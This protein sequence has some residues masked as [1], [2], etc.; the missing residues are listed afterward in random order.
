MDERNPVAM[1]GAYLLFYAVFGCLALT[2]VA[3]AVAIRL[4][5]G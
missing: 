5:G 1:T 3:G 2:S 4:F